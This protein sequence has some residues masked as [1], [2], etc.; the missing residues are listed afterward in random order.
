MCFGKDLRL[1]ALRACIVHVAATLFA[2]LRPNSAAAQFMANT[3][4]QAGQ[5]TFLAH[6]VIDAVGYG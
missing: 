3:S 2:S 4:L 1:S 5:I 6:I